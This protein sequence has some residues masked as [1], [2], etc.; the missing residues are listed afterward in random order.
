MEH[1]ERR[2]PAAGGGGGGPPPR[3]CPPP[4]PPL[5]PLPSRPAASAWG[6][7]CCR[8]RR[9][10]SRRR[11]RTRPP[12]RGSRT[13]WRPAFPTSRCSRWVGPQLQPAAGKLGLL[14][15][16]QLHCLAP[17]PWQPGSAAGCFSLLPF[18]QDEASYQPGLLGAEMSPGPST[19][20]AS[21]AGQLLHCSSSNG[22]AAA[23]AAAAAEQGAAQQAQQAQQRR[24]RRSNTWSAQVRAA[25]GRLWPVCLH[26]CMPQQLPCDV[27]LLAH[28]WPAEGSHAGSPAPSRRA[29]RLTTG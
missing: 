2:R 15:G 4:P 25:M 18:L 27:L 12:R 22:S 21:T 29:R 3:R 14:C 17:C 19:H 23:A 26:A 13:G 20:G 28:Q 7:S 9:R 1:S 11:W 5:L 10:R 16:A 6:C 24:P 8:R